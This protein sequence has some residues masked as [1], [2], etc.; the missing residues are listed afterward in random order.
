MCKQTDVVLC[1]KCWGSSVKEGTRDHRGGTDQL[2]R[3]E[4]GQG[5]REE[6]TFELELERQPEFPLVHKAWEGIPG[7]A[8]MQG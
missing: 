8:D 3:G 1:G 5:F 2:C 4:T 7:G 6:V